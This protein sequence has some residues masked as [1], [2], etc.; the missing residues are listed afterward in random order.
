L[1]LARDNPA[2]GLAVDDQILVHEAVPSGCVFVEDEHAL[3]SFRAQAGGCERIGKN[4]K[5]E[6]WRQELMKIIKQ[7]T[8]PIPRSSSS[9]SKSLSIALYICFFCLCVCMKSMREEISGAF[10]LNTPALEA[11]QSRGR[12]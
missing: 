3:S 9:I 5:F 8:P 4:K 10:G 7:A 11:W 2:N 12:R 6:E 1:Q